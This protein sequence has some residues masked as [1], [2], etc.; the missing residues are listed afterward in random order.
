MPGSLTSGMLADVS[1]S[2][3]GRSCLGPKAKDVVR[4]QQNQKA[5]VVI[6]SAALVESAT[7]LRA[8]RQEAQRPAT[9]EARQRLH[10]YL[11]DSAKHRPS[12]ADAGGLS[13]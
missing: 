8:A 3:P 12:H 1:A 11:A 2:K 7:L 5:A 6:L 9:E 4:R 13:A 10:K